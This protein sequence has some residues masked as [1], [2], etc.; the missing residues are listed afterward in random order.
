LINRLFRRRGV[1][2]E[3]LQAERA[4]CGL[5]CIAMVASYF[6]KWVDLNTLRRDY[7][8]S[9]RGTG[10]KELISVASGLGLNARALR[11][12]P[13]DLRHLQL[14]AVLHWDMMHFVVLRRVLR[15]G[16]EVHDPAVGR[17]RYSWSEVGR[18]FTGVALEMLPGRS[19]EAGKS[20]LI[21]RL[22]DLFVRHPGFNLAVAQLVV[23]SLC[24][25]LA[26]IGMAFYLQLVI[27]ESLAKQDRDFLVMVALG[28]LLLALVTVAMNYA[29]DSVRLYFSNQLGF[30]MVGNVF[31]HLMSLPADFFEKRHV[32]D[33]ISRFSSIREIRNTL[34]EDIITVFL[35]GVLALLTLL[36]M[37]Y[38]SPLLAWIALAFTV[39]VATLR[40]AMIPTFKALSEQKIIAEAATNSGL[41]ENMRAIE[42]LKFYG[43][44]VPRIQ[45]WR[46]A[47]AEQINAQVMLSRF[48]INIEAVYEL[49]FGIENVLLIYVAALLVLDGSLS[50]GFLTAFVALKGN[51]STSLKSFIDKLV[52]V[53]LLRLQ[54]ERVSDIT[55][56]PRE[57]DSF[58]LSRL[59]RPIVGRLSLLDVGF[60]Y[61]GDPVP[62]LGN[63][64][65]EV[66]PGEIVA[67]IGES[68]SGKST[69]MKLAAGL[70]TPA[71]GS[72]QVDGADIRQFGIRE[73]RDACAGILQTDQLLSG[74]LADNITLFAE[75]VDHEQL[76]RAAAMAGVDDVVAAL[77]MGYNSLVG[78][79]GSALSAGQA[80]RILL[81]R[82][83]YK[84]AKL[85]FLDEAT[86]N[87]DPQS[88][89]AILARLKELSRQS[90]VAILMVTHREAPLAI[91]ARIYC[92]NDGCVTLLP[93]NEIP[94]PKT[95]ST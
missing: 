31:N 54:L 28:F 89:G 78:D 41:I 75:E 16:I 59:R 91:A 44:E 32:G 81:A 82:A 40:L 66:A 58:H 6:G 37:F 20:T 27:D 86:A 13:A 26:S 71:S 45:Q 14:P 46:N 94:S 51:F 74:T 70:L 4:E 15:G 79:M 17:R 65:L 47:Y 84:G 33:L 2:P 68:G 38:F 60:R 23:L 24:L 64:H 80:Q 8:M 9:G 11:L 95:R 88:E 10:L 53:R 62:V 43:R 93:R 1:L 73:Y 83:F 56:A 30:Q 19:F 63:V 48:S 18:H 57:F 85:L 35:D 12:E 49:L 69:L 25:Q 77:P 90:G 3:V 7:P 36:V 22:R 21:S 67:L 72:V 34:T 39:A 29:R 55:C 87:L 76:E 42:I 5:A 61:S 50:L 52:Q 92:C